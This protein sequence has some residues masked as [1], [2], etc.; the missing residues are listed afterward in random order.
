[1]RSIGWRIGW[2]VIALVIVAG[3]SVRDAVAGE[4]RRASGFSMYLADTET[5]MLPPGE[6]AVVIVEN[7]SG[8]TE[9]YSWSASQDGKAFATGEVVVAPAMQER[10][11]VEARKGGTWTVFSVHG[12]AAMLQWQWGEES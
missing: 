12:K 3:S 2:G 5:G 4:D 9:T 10:I 6:A 7:H 1:M 11:W 8:K